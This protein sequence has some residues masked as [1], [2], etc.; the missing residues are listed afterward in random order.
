MAPV[1]TA[2]ATYLL[3][4][5][6][7]LYGA[8]LAISHPWVWEGERWKELVFA[9][10]AQVSDLSEDKVRELTDQLDYL[11]LLDIPALAELCRN[12]QAPDPNDLLARRILELLQEKG[13]S[14]AQAKRGLGA[15]CEAALGLAEHF[16]GKVQN[17]LRSYGELMSK[18]FS[19]F[20]LFSTLNA[21]EVQ[22]AF[23][24]WLQN[25][26]NVPMS[27]LDQNIQLFCQQHG[28]K[29]AQLIAAA[30]ELD[31]NLALLDDLVQQ[32]LAEQAKADEMQ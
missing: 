2:E 5:A 4:K 22:A 12:R 17:Y 1:N 26:L 6:L 24:Y 23:V 27:L 14:L 9:L 25:V 8:E 15:I 21:S 10:L 13:L 19:R 3:R 7:S 16:N 11:D 30:D 28:L 32:L 20:F 18:E 29:P 31:L